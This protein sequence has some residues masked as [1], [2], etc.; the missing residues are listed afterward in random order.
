MRSLLRSLIVIGLALS[1]VS[2]AAAAVPDPANSTCPAT[3]TIAPDGSCCFDVIV[4]DAANNPVAGSTVNVDFGA[5]PVTFCPAQPP[6]VTVVGNGV[7]VVT[8]A[9]GRAHICICASFTGPC[10]ATIRADGVTLCNVPMQNNC[11][12]TGTQKMFWG[13]LKVIYR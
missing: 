8:D 6:G 5:C 11:Q 3:V 12:P 1:A 4:R 2:G 7:N 10:S 13:R 9:T